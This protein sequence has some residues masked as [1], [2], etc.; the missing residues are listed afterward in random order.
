MNR[1]DINGL[2]LYIVVTGGAS[3]GVGYGGILGVFF[4]AEDAVKCCENDGFDSTAFEMW[5]CRDGKWIEY[6]NGRDYD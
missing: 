5:D 2:R 4:T 6:K 3:Q 1:Q